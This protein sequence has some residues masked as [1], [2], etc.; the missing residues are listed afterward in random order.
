MMYCALLQELEA[1]AAKLEEE[2]KKIEESAASLRTEK[3]TAEQ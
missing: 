1:M 3:D 2:K